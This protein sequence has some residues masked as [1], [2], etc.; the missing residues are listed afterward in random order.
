VPQQE[1]LAVGCQPAPGCE[2]LG[3]LE[4]QA[5]LVA[6][7]VLENGVPTTLKTCHGRTFQ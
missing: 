7:L 3:R 5:Q 2:C 1:L 6:V 4:K